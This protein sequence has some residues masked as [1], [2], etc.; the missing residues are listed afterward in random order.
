MYRSWKF[1]QLEDEISE[2]QQCAIIFAFDPANDS[3]FIEHIATFT[4]F[5]SSPSSSSSSVS[6]SS[7]DIIAN[8]YLTASDQYATLFSASKA[9]TMQL[10]MIY[11]PSYTSSDSLYP[12]F[13]ASKKKYK[14]VV[15]K[16]CLVIT[17]LP[18]RFRI[19]RNIMGDPLEYMPKLNPHPPL[20]FVLT[21][22]YTLERKD[23]INRN[24]PRDFF[25]PE[26]RNLMHN[27]I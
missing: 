5:E 23:I 26:E 25:W 22:H 2:T 13:A 9:D 17:D 14:P 15:L 11:S 21:S 20:T 6:I 24:H 18:N 3:L 12:T 19:V 27:F 7:S 1:S 16:V 10:Y 4:D 8:L